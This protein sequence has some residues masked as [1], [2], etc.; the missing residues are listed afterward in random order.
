MGDVRDLVGEKRAPAAAAL[1]PARHAGLEEE[2][3][4][5]ELTASV[6]Q[7]GRARRAAGALESIRLVN[8]HPRHPATLGGQRV[9]RPG[10]RL[11][12]GQQLQ[13]A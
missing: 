13:A 1:G 6:E 7:V 5:D 4:D 9:A 2:A 11:L 8:G 3:V 12:L 10:E